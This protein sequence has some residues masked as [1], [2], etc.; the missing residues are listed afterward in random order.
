MLSL[1]RYQAPQTPIPFTETPGR[2]LTQIRSAWC[3]PTAHH[4]ILYQHYFHS[5]NPF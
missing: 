4:A 3:A 2:A 5:L 1:P